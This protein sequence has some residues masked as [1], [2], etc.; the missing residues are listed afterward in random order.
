MFI[1]DWKKNTTASNTVDAYCEL[2]NLI[3]VNNN[4]EVFPV[5]TFLK[6]KDDVE[7]PR[8]RNY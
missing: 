7:R 8:R 1:V 2:L 3:R 6:M 4:A 5:K